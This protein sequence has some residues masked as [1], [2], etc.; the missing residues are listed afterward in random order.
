[1]RGRRTVTTSRQAPRRPGRVPS[2]DVNT[3]AVA[4]PA[5][6]RLGPWPHDHDTALLILLDHHMVPTASDVA[7]WI[8]DARATGARAVRTGA[9][10]PDATGVF[11]DAG[12]HTVDTLALLTRPLDSTTPT[13]AGPT[14]RLRRGQ[15]PTA[16]EID[17]RSFDGAWSN[18]AA[19]LAEIMDATPKHRSRAVRVDRT[20]AGFAISGLAAR[21]GYL[22]RLA[23]DPQR[24]R[25][26][27]ARDLVTDAL[28]WMRRHGADLAMV[29]TAIDNEAALSLYR[30]F[31]FVERPAPLTILARDLVAP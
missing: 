4:R 10:F 1:M 8:A 21:T 9:L 15:L 31:G 7:R 26:G 19:T 30:S 22:Q 2:D 6:A 23:V 27:I 24:R 20:M 29:N 12:F 17:A 28:A 13:A 14:R 18:D 25:R 11:V 3:T 16:A 5:R